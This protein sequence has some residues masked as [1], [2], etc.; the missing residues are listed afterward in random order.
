MAPPQSPS[1]PSGASRAPS[2]SERALLV[3]GR[4]VLASLFVLG[5][6]AKIASPDLYLAMMGEAGLAP[7]RLLLN[8][9]IALELGGGLWLAAGARAHEIAAVALAAHTLLVNLFLHPFWELAGPERIDEISFF[10]K[11]V[12]IVGGLLFVAGAA[13]REH[14]LAGTREIH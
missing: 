10:F 1:S 4:V 7:A 11:N 6:I 14:R 2:G 12:A 5:G 13:R 9:V 8:L 3:G